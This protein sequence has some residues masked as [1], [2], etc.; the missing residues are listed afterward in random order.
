MTARYTHPAAIVIFGGTGNLAEKKLLP[1]LFH[2]YMQQML[3]VHFVIIGLARR[4]LTH[5]S[6]QQFVRDCILAK[7]PASDAGLLE[8]FCEQVRYASGSFDDDSSYAQVKQELLTFD[9][10]IG[11]CTSKLFYLAVP[12]D[13]YSEIFTKLHASAVMELC[14]GV[15]S[16]SRILVEKPFGSDLTTAVALE[17]QLVELY[18]ENQIY[19]IDH[20]LAKESIENIMSLRFANSILADSWNGSRIESITLRLYESQDVSTRGSFYDKIGTL[21]DVGQNHLLQMLALLTMAPPDVHSADAV[22]ASRL[23]AITSL[24]VHDT[25]E[26]VRGQYRGYRDTVGVDKESDTETYFKIGTHIDSVLWHNVGVTLES[27]KALAEAFTEA[28]ITFRPIDV[29]LCGAEVEPHYHRNILRMKFS[30]DENIVLTMWVKEP[31]FGFVLHERKLVLASNEGERYRSPE[32]YE[33]VL[34]DCIVGDQTRF[35]SG[36]EV[37]AAWKFITPILESFKQLPLH[38]YNKGSH[39]PITISEV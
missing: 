4:A 38:Q 10:S 3:P 21:R 12:P 25:D 37:I 13:L 35:V 31:G 20:Y 1:A 6:Y 14:D 18:T 33:R 30:P 9:A 19:R 23:A 22:R 26:Q 2:L 15:N 32:A 27:G 24:V 36:P 11:Q 8:R 17:Q 29:C 39:T 7:L 34:Y 16:W 5:E 28:V